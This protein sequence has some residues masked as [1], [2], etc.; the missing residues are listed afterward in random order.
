MSEICV[1]QVLYYEAQKDF[2]KKRV[3][4]CENCPIKCKCEKKAKEEGGIE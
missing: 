4:E 3:L 1:V 2:K